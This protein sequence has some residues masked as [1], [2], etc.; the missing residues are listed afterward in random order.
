MPEANKPVFSIITPTCNRPLLL[1][2]TIGSILR[3]TYTDFEHIII[4][5]AGNEETRTL[6]TEIDDERIVFIKNKNNKGPAGC[7]NSGLQIA[8]G[9]Y[10]LFLDDDDEYL[11][12]FLE[13]MNNRISCARDETGFIWTGVTRIKDTETGEKPIASLTWPSSFAGKEEG[14]VAATSIGTGYGVCIKR[15]CFD[16]T[17]LYDESLTTSEDTEFLFRLA[18]KFEFETIPEVL[19][20]L[21]QHDLSQL[22]NEKNR[23]VHLQNRERVLKMHLD[24]LIK[25]P[26]LFFVHYKVVANLYYSLKLKSKG[27]KTMF[28]IIKNTPF[29]IWNFTDLIFYELAGKDTAS[30]YYGSFIRK[31]ILYF[32]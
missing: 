16:T 30:L 11:P 20:K 19:V 31:I 32:K 21:H 23:L 12:E 28:S 9:R 26:R 27:R 29:R 5:D 22:T 6:V 15:E 18:G 10:F 4:D 7:R 25:H 2:R 3:Q 24:L 14:L 13:R 8:K 1:K 17:G